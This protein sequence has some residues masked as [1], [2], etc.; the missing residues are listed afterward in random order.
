VPSRCDRGAS[1]LRRRDAGAMESCS[2]RR[3]HQ[4]PTS[5]RPR[6]NSS[7][8]ALA[9]ERNEL[10]C[11]TSRSS[12]QRTQTCG[13][14]ALLRWKRTTRADLAGPLRPDCREDR[15][16]PRHRRLG[17]APR[18]RGRSDLAVS[19]HAVNV[20]PLQF[21]VPISV[22]GSAHPGA[23]GFD[24]RR[25]AWKSPKAP[26]WRPSTPSAGDGTAQGARAT[27][28]LDDFGTGY[29]SLN[30]LRRSRSAASRSTA[31]S[32]PTS[33]PRRCTIVHA[34]ASIGRSLG[35]KLVAEGI[36]TAEQHRSCMQP[37][38]IS[39]RATCSG[40]R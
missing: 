10:F 20:S 25:L 39:C 23:T 3:R 19:H 22:I 35:L 27:F 28:A 8:A 2:R 40:A 7:G 11:S 31:A 1:S 4:A 38:F 18:V 29:S 36:E 5:C 16:H 6:A 33:T 24:G 9:L 26:C 37:A 13:V 34:I 30:Y 21:A 17:A 14:E 32:S 15:A 12:M